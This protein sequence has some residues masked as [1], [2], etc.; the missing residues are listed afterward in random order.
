MISLRVCV[1]VYDC[2]CVCAHDCVCV[3]AH[4]SEQISEMHT[5]QP[6]CVNVET[7]PLLCYCLTP[8]CWS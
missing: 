7:P 8:W 5:Q 2:V 4:A 6:L 3:C 1:R